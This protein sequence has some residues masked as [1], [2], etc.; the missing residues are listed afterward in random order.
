MRGFPLGGPD[1]RIRIDYS[2]I[3][4]GNQVR[5]KLGTISV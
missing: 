5:R 4:P 1:R 2:D 3:E